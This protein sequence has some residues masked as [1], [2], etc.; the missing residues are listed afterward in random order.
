[1]IIS[2]WVFFF[3]IVISGGIVCVCMFPLFGIV[4]VGLSISCVFVGSAKFLGLEFSF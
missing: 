1:M 3:G 2:S 4:G